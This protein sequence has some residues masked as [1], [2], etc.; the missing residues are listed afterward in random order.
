MAPDG[1][2]YDTIGRTYSATRREDPRIAA[3]IHAAIGDAGSVVNLGAGTGSYEPVGPTVVAV[4]PSA[5]MVAQR[6]GRSALVVRAVGEALPFPD[7]SFDVALA[8]LTLHHWSDLDRGLREMRRVSRRQ[9]VLYFEPLRTHRFWG[10]EYFPEAAELAIE[11]HAPGEQELRRVL[12]V[13]EV[14]PVLVPKDCVDGFGT[15]FWAR[16]EAYLDPTVQAG[17]SWLALLPQEVRDRGAAELARDLASGEWD[18]RFGQLR[19][20]AEFDGGYRIAIGGG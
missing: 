6:D 13:R 3:H 10:L 14:R 20:L 7:H 16:P 11:V 9:V 19:L 4:E 8:V 18:R 5:A 15:A 17:M 2:A 12:Q 1:T